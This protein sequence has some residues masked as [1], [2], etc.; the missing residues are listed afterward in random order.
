MNYAVITGVRDDSLAVAMGLQAGDRI[1][2][3]NNKPVRDLIQFQYEW[4]GEEVALEVEKKSGEREVYEIDKEYDEPLG[5]EFEQAVFDGLKVCTNKCVFCFVDQMPQDLRPSLYVKD[6]DYR[7]SFLQGSFITMTNLHAKDIERIKNEH[8]SP[9]YV[10]VHTTDPA[11]RAKMLNNK[12]AGKILEIMKDL[13]A[14]EIEFHTQVVLCPGLND[15]AALEQTYRDLAA[16]KGVKSLAI[17]PV[18]LTRH[19]GKLPALRMVDS[20]SARQ[21]IDWVSAR[22]RE[23]RKSR[24]TS[25]VWL[26]DEFYLLAGRDIPSY[27]FYED[28][29]Q[30]E[31]GVGM[32][33][34]LWE[35][36]DRFP[37]PRRISPAREV[38]FV[39]G[40]SG[41]PAI[42]P[43][44]EKLNTVTGLRIHLITAINS[45]FGPTVTVTGLLTGRCLL[46][47]L[48][49]IKPH[50][51]VFIPSLMLRAQE[52]RFLDDLTPEEVGNM[53]QVNLEVVPV[54][55]DQIWERILAIRQP[56]REG[57]KT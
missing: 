11:L 22:Q 26:S 2:S 51:T 35:D 49:G 39:T 4:A 8:L 42:L 9:L 53:L 19:R 45:F 34:L 52:G 41:R 50:S 24:G 43:V 46:T 27:R 57:E 28:F 17:V 29:P 7:L 33:R 10:S 21:L 25:F 16:L 30:L 55:A 12:A 40:V 38:I 18:G 23:C 20:A 5:A 3:V 37:L 48:S 6:D 13:A 36:F 56:V 44:I 14:S 31:N 54:K 1:V 15:G 47:A 32:V